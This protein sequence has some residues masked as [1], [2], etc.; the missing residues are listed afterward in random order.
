MDCLDNKKPCLL[1]GFPFL[2]TLYK[3]TFYAGKTVRRFKLFST[4]PK[5][6]RILSYDGKKLIILT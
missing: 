1:A 4:I 2:M 6:K 3:K 5:F